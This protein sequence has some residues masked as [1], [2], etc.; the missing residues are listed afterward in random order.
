VGLRAGIDGHDVGICWSNAFPSNCCKDRIWRARMM[1]ALIR[2]EDGFELRVVYY[3]LGLVVFGLEIKELQ[4]VI[5]LAGVVGPV[6]GL[7]DASGQLRI[8]IHS[9]SSGII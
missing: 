1:Q 8:V 4:Q 2:L 9:L 6:H 5:L 7:L 3:S